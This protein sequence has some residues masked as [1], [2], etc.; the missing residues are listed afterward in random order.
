MSS[1]VTEAE[2]VA[3]RARANAAQIA[4]QSMEASERVFQ[5]VVSSARVKLATLR[6]NSDEVRR[7]WEIKVQVVARA[8]AQAEAAKA[9]ALEVQSQANAEQVI[10]QTRLLEQAEASE[11]LSRKER[12]L[13]WAQVLRVYAEFNAQTA[14]ARQTLF[15]EWRAAESRMI[16]AVQQVGGISMDIV[17]KAKMVVAEA[18]RQH[19]ILVEAQKASESAEAEAI[20]AQEE[21]MTAYAAAKQAERSATEV[22]AAERRNFTAQGLMKAASLATAQIKK[23]KEAMDKTIAEAEA[24]F[25]LT[26]EEATYQ[27][28]LF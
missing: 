13:A 23:Q 1:E 28:A 26:L 12:D 2:A 21:A 16:S 27:T 22:H 10:Y 19:F 9:R 11:L 25:K 6:A 3:V 18:Q 24:A 7:Q 8:R 20:A 5:G 14:R 15:E 17:E 4:K